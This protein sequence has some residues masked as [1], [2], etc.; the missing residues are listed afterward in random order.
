MDEFHALD[1]KKIDELIHDGHKM[2]ECSWIV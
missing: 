2:N 1:E